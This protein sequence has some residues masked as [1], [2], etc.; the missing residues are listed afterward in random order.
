MTTKKKTAPKRRSRQPK[1]P[2]YSAVRNWL[3]EHYE[4][5]NLT[6]LEGREFDTAIVGV[7][8][9][10]NLPPAVV[11]DVNRLVPIIMRKH[12]CSFEDALD[13]VGYNVTG[14]SDGPNSPLFINVYKPGHD[15]YCFDASCPG[16][17][18]E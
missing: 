13:H 14:F 4:D 15:A 8:D 5:D 9:R 16:E 7:A 3:E 1:R 2:H 17:H 18:C 11:Y 10:V 12:R 6:L